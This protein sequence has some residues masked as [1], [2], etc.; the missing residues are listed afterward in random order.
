[1]LEILLDDQYVLVNGHKRCTNF[2]PN[3]LLR[4]H[5]WLGK[6]GVFAAVT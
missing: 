6:S 3:E 5:Q 2:Y 1:M 4:E